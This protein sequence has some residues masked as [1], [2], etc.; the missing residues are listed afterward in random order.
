MQTRVWTGVIAI[1][2]L[3]L[4]ARA[5]DLSGTWEGTVSQN[6]KTQAYAYQMVLSQVAEK[7]SGTATATSADGL[8]SAQFNLAGVWERGRLVLQEVYQIDPKGAPWCLKYATLQ[9][10]TDG[11]GQWQL[12]GP[13]EADGCAPGTMRLRKISAG[14]PPEGAEN[15]FSIF[16][17]WIGHINQSDRDYAF[18]YEVNLEQ[19]GKGVARIVSEAAGG[20]GRLALSWSY[21]P[22]NDSLLIRE[23]RVLEKTDPQWKWC[24]KTLRLQLQREA[25]HD[26]FRGKWTGYIEG[27]MPKTGACAPGQV[28]LEKPVMNSDLRENMRLLQRTSTAERRILIQRSVEVKQSDLVLKIWDNGT[29][30]GDV[31]TVFLNG[32][33][34]LHQHKLTKDPAT[35]RVKLEQQD[36]FLIVYAD[37]LGTIQPNTVALAVS[38][39]ER[40]QVLL[41]HSDLRETGAALIRQFKLR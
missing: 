20:S 35:L 34:I 22:A 24:L 8:A 38:D 39:G 36:N 9:L 31:I 6:N 18:V 12:Q 25:A 5:Q 3:S 10:G 28:Y 4:S 26:A 30:D 15:A 40:E 13:W 21:D 7:V 37:D 23:E 32:Q 19:G 41:L 2:L 14:A 33:K 29:E 27:T 16:G 17:N 11:Q 1:I